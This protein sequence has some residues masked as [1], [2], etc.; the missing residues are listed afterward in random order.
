LA[1]SN[2]KIPTSIKFC[3]DCGT[4]APIQ[5]ILIIP[6]AF[7]AP[8]KTFAGRSL[9]LFAWPEIIFEAAPPEFLDKKPKEKQ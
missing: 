3:R 5:V 6:L 1:I 7:R 2:R 9:A 8:A 4:I